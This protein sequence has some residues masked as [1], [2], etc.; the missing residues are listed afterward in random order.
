MA[1]KSSGAL[2]PVALTDELQPSEEE[3]LPAQT[4]DSEETPDTTTES[5]AAKT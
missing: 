1:M 2:L 3:L 4:A 5:V